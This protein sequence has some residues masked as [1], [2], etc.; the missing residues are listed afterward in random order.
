M[1]FLL[2]FLSVFVFV[3]VIVFSLRSLLNEW[4]GYSQ[5]SEFC[6]KQ[7]IYI[8]T[9]TYYRL[10]QKAELTRLVHTFKLVNCLHWILIEDN[11]TKS[12]L[13][14]VLLSKSGLKYTHLYEPTPHFQKI[15]NKDPRWKKA[16]GVLQRNKGLEWIRSSKINNGIVYFADDDNTYDLE[17]FEEVLI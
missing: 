12:K 14:Q 1:R 3:V 13:V 16:R 5:T 17:L 9:P 10:T 6:D 8:I 7:Q 2:R 11:I 4:Y 15:S